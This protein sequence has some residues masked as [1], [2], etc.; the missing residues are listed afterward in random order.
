MVIGTT[1][2]KDVLR[3]MEM[4]DSFSAVIRSHYLTESRHLMAALEGMEA[5][6]EF[7][8]LEKKVKGKG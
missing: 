4:L 6:N 1:S 2:R 7:S 3:D 5:F 8:K